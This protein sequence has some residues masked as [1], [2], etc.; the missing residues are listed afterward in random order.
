MKWN[1]IN[2]EKQHDFVFKYGQGLL[3]LV[4]QNAKKVL[5]VGCGTGDLTDKLRKRGYKVL[6]IDQSKNMI[7]EAQKR[8]PNTKFKIKDIL[9][10]A[11]DK[12]FDV[13]FSNA[14][15]HWINNQQ[16]LLNQIHNLLNPGGYLICEF[17][18]HNNVQTICEEFGQELQEIGYSY[19]NP[20]FFPTVHEYKSQLVNHGFKVIHIRDFDRPTPLQGGINGLYNWIRQFFQED[21]SHLNQQQQKQVLNKMAV[22][23]KEKLWRDDHWEADYRRLRLVCQKN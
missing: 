5:D 7:C 13:V 15:F 4:P 8:Y 22:R 14:V 1:A 2:Y 6:G 16:M 3:S 19:Q 20:F 23:L 18:G 21:L 10:M 11:T 17:G 12:K 9:T